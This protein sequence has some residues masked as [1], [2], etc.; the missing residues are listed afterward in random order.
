MQYQQPQFQQAYRGPKQQIF[1]GNGKPYIQN[2]HHKSY[3]NGYAHQ[4]YQSYHHQ[5]HYA[6]MQRP[7]TQVIPSYPRYASLNLYQ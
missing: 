7:T 4:P 2:S 1:A 6:S 5:I 3:H